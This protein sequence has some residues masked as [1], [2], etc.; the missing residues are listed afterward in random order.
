MY[1]GLG[2]EVA[3]NKELWYGNLW[4]ESARFGQASVTVN[5]GNFK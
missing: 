1:F 5:Q 2:Q 3:K 4:K